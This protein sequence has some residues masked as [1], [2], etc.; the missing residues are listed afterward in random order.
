MKSPVVYPRGFLGFD[1]GL[2]VEN[3]STN[4]SKLLEAVRLNKTLEITSSCD[5]ESSD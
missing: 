1:I 4:L 2:P 3:R 5:I